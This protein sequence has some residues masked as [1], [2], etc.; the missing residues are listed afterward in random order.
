MVLLACAN[1]RAAELTSPDHQHQAS[2]SP[3]T[4]NAC[5]LIDGAIVS[6][7]GCTGENDAAPDVPRQGL[8]Q[9]AIPLQVA[10]ARLAPNVHAVSGLAWAPDSRHL[11]YLDDIADFLAP[12]LADDPDGHTGRFVHHRLFLAVTAPG[13]FARGWWLADTCVGPPHWRDAHI[14]SLRCGSADMT[15]DV[16]AG[17]GAVR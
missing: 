15:Y 16:R 12:R 17:G 5:V 1:A 11:A 7:P 9:P 10:G 2:V 8:P 4:M 13:A 14:V 3:G 6:Y